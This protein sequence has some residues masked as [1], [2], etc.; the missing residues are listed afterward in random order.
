MISSINPSFSGRRDNIDAAIAVDDDTIRQIAYLQT[1]AKVDHK[2]NRRITNTLFYSA[3]LAAGLATAVLTKSG[4]TK[5][6]SKEVSGL[7]ARAAKGL[8]VGALWTAALASIDLLGY[9]KRKLAE[10]SSDVRKFDREHPFLSVAALIAAGFGALCLLDKGAAKL[11]AK[12]APEFLQKGTER[13]AKFIN[14]N[15][16]IQSAKKNAQKLAEKSPSALKEIGA[17]V[18]DWSPSLLLLGGLFH[19]ISSVGRENR[20]FTNNYMKLKDRQTRL[21]QARVRELSMENDFL[22][23][24]AKNREDVALVKDPVKDLPDEVIDRI[25][26]LH[27]EI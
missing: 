17:T 8:K 27:E 15:S 4:N 22:M 3:P 24:D 9:G 19:S 2:K 18:L 10:N 13:V 21:S 20:E 26:S 14:N 23:Q 1:A 11:A 12:K 5:I 25:E 6:F 16:V 7:A